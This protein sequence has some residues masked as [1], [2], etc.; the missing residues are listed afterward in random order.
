MNAKK[1]YDNLKSLLTLDLFATAISLAF[2]SIVSVIWLNKPENWMMTITV[3]LACIVTIIN[4]I[5]LIHTGKTLTKLGKCKTQEEVDNVYISRVFLSLY[6][7]GKYGLIDQLPQFH[8]AL[9]TLSFLTTI[10][11][12]TY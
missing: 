4:T 3:V 8:V 7:N 2:L 12:V 5:E 1:K 10:F 6:D 9:T 11:I